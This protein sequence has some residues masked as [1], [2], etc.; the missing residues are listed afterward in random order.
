MRTR[1]YV[2]DRLNE[3]YGPTPEAF[4]ALAGE[5]LRLVLTLDCGTRSF[6]ALE[7]ALKSGLEVLVIDHH[8]PGALASARVRS[9]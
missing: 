7:S 2:P 4:A 3:G 5:G 8:L 9:R 1:L 6:A